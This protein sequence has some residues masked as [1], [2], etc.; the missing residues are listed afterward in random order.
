MKPFVPREKMN[1]KARR[2]LDAAQRAGWGISPV[3]RRKENKKVYNRKR[4]Q[5]IRLDEPLPYFIYQKRR[6][7]PAGP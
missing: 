3:T 7:N 5:Q 2:E 4:K 6:L 1:K